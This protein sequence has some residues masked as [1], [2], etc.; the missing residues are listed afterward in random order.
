[1]LGHVDIRMTLRYAHL[2][3]EG[4]SGG[5]AGRGGVKLIVPLAMG[6]I[7]STK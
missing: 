4:K 7:T 5:E 2:A 1:M 3:P 6:A